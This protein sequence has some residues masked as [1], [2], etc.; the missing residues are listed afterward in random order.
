MHHDVLII[1]AGINGLLSALTLAREGLRVRVVERGEPARESTWAGA[2]ILSPLMPWDYGP[3]VNALSDRGR[4][5]WPGWIADLLQRGQVD[6]EYQR[7]GMLVLATPD[8]DRV[9]SWCDAHDWPAGAA[10]EAVRDLGFAAQESIWLP[11]VAQVRNPRLAQSLAAACQAEGVTLQADTPALGLQVVNNRIEAVQTPAGPMPADRVVITSGAWSQTLLG[12]LAG[13]VRIEPVRGQILLF[14]AEPGLLPCMVYGGGHYLVPRKDGLILAGSTL[15]YA[16]FE[17]TVTEAAREALHRFALE[18][19]PAL[20]GA[21]VVHQ[22]AG[23]RPGSPGNVPTISAHP[24]LENLFLNSGH[25]RYGVT[26]APASVELLRDLMLGRAPVLDP[27]PY[28]WKAD[29][30][31]ADAR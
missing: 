18:A 14:R 22:W 27:A 25:F 28:G 8:H 4:A 6:P 31:R 15:E 1:G 30:T 26:M 29:R 7:C 10:P 12:D 5:L 17:K 2:G 23:L 16:G 21:E 19:F 11:D 9:L 24:A 20:A 3:E 13:Q